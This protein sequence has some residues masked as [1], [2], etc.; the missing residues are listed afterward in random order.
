MSGTGGDI[1]ESRYG[2]WA[3]YKELSGIHIWTVIERDESSFQD[4]ALFYHYRADGSIQRFQY[5]HGIEI[6]SA[7]STLITVEDEQWIDLMLEDDIA[8]YVTT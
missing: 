4:V 6:G 1:P 8:K 7:G 2:I 5:C 3:Y